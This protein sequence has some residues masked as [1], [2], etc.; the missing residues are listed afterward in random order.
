MI[1]PENVSDSDGE[2]I[3]LLNLTGDWLDLYGYYILDYGSDRCEIAEL[4]PG[5]MIVEPGGYLLVCANDE[6]WD[7]GGIHCDGSF[8]YSTFGGGFAMSNST[9]EVVLASP[10]GTLVDSVSYSEGFA[11]VGASMGVDPDSATPSGNDHAG[12]W[13]DQWAFLPQGDNGNPG[14]ENDW[15]W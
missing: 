2:W 10:Y 3:E 6:Y 5:S 8:H 12:N 15:C 13:C 1:N 7:N 14:E 11:P 4:S 9:D